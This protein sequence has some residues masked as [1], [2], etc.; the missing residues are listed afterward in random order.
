MNSYNK[1]NNIKAVLIDKNVNYNNLVFYFEQRDKYLNE[2]KDT[3]AMIFTLESKNKIDLNDITINSYWSIEDEKGFLKIDNIDKLKK[4]PDGLYKI[5][6]QTG[7]VEFYIYLTSSIYDSEGKEP[8]ERKSMILLDD[9]KIYGKIDVPTNF[10]LDLRSENYKIIPSI[11]K[12]NIKIMQ[13]DNKIKSKF[14]DYG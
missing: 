13:S 6:K 4:L 11:K 5:K 9:N 7:T 10:I 14:I 1:T 12:E 2:A 3:R 8:S